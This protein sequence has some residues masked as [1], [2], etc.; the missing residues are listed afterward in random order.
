MTMPTNDTDLPALNWT[1][2]S[3]IVYIAFSKHQFYLRS[4]ISAYVLSAGHTP[5]SPFMNFDYNLGDLVERQAIRIANNSLLHASDE[6]W[7][8]G[9]VSDGVLVEIYQAMRRKVPVRYFDLSKRVE[10]REI[11]PDDVQ[12]ED[13][14]DWMWQMVLT[15]QNLERWHPRLRFY[16][17]Y[18]IVYPAYSKH[19]FFWQMHISKYCLDHKMVPLN[20]FMLFRYFLGDMV[21]R[22]VVYRANNTIVQSADAIWVFGDIA[23]GVLA[24]IKLARMTG[25][26]VQY[27]AITQKNPVEFRRVASDRM[28][29]ELPDLER[30]RSEL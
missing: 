29:F 5:I 13:V 14:S 15:G 3:K 27:F 16:K 23:D 8:F 26:P 28:Q 1:E 9:P 6:L 7:V 12:L 17:S 11:S 2:K 4:H 19:N 22:E 25:R 24:E 10:I 30:Y 18:P 20:P 21:P